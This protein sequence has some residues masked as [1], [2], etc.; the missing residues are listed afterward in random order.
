MCCLTIIG[1]L[2]S[3]LLSTPAVVAEQRSAEL[4]WSGLDWFGQA[5]VDN[6]LA[7]EV[8][9]PA[10]VGGEQMPAIF[11][12][13]RERGR[14]TAHFPTVRTDLAPGRRVFFLGH[15]GISDGFDW[16]DSQRAP[17]GVRF[18][19]AADGLDL[20]ATELRESIWR[21]VVA[22]LPAGAGPWQTSLTLATDCGAVG[23][24]NYDWAVFGDPI[25]VAV[26]ERPLPAEVLV[27]GTGGVLVAQVAGGAGAL[28]VEG[29]SAEGRPLEG[30]VATT[31]VPPDTPLAAVRFDFGSQPG[32]IGWRW[33]A[34]GLQVAQAWG[35]SWG[36]QAVIE[37]FGPAQAVT[38]NGEPLRVRVILGNRGL[39]A[40]VPEHGMVVECGGQ[41]QRVEH[42]GPGETAPFEFT[43]GL[44]QPESPAVRAA[45]MAGDQSQST[46]MAGGVLVWP[47]P[48]ELPADRPGTARAV[49]LSDDYV[50]V[51]NRHCR[52]L[53]C[54]SVPGLGALVYV[55]ADAGWELAGSVVPFV[56]WAEGDNGT[57]TPG[58]PVVVAQTTP[59]GVR[60]EATTTLRSWLCRILAELPD[61]TP[62]LKVTLTVEAQQ[63]GQL[64]ALWGPAVHAGDRA[65]GDRKGIAIFPGLE[66][67]EGDEPS[68]STRD[69]A[70][71]HHLRQVPH[72][73]KITVP[74]MMVET[75]DGGPVL[76]VAWDPLQKWEG[77]HS[78]PAACFSSPDRLTHQAS[79]L[80]QLML[81]S[82]PEF[83][84]EN[85]R[86]AVRPLAV[87]PG[88]PWQLV[89]YLVAGQPEPDA[90]A[91]LLWFD[92]LVGYPPAEEAPRSFEDEVA[93][94]RHG[95]MVTCWDPD[96]K[97]GR[98]VVGWGS[99]NSPGFATLMLMD[100]RAVARGEAQAQVAERVDLIGQQTLREQGPPGLASSANCHIMGWE[101]PFHWGSLPGA[102][103]GMRGAAY[104]SLGSQE[105]DGGWGYYPDE[106]RRALGEPGT[107][108]SGI[109]GQNAYL[110]AKYAAISGDPQVLA[111]MTRA[112]ERLRAFKVPRGAQGWECPILEPDVLASAYCLRACVWAY[113]ATGDRRYLDDARFWARTGLPFQYAWDD[114]QRPGMRYASIPVFGSTFFTHSWIGLPVQWCGLVYAYGLQELMRFEPDDLWRRQVEG[115]T[116]SAMHQQWPL[117]HPELAGTYPDSYGNWFTHRNPVFINPENIQLNLLALHGLDPGLRSVPLPTDVG[118]LHVTGP[119][120]LQARAE[121]GT[122]EVRAR[123]LPDQIM[124]LTLAPVAP[125]DQATVTGDTVLEPTHDLPTGS[126]GWAYNAELRILVVGVRCDGQGEARLRIS[127]FRR[128]EA[129][130]AVTADRWEFET[131]V[132]GW[133]PGNACNVMW[134]QGAL[135]IIATGFDP[136][137][138][139]SPT[140]INARVA[141]KLG[142][143]VRLTGGRAVG[144]FW[145]TRTSPH[146]GEDKHV[147]VPVPADG[148]WHELEVDLSDQRLWTGTVEQLR[149]DIEPAEVA[150]GTTL[151]VDWIRPL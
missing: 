85:A 41:R 126:T 139:S 1:H 63:P 18:Y 125:T 107:R 86:R 32:C 31:R 111:G 120:D 69:L 59:E 60:L 113:M 129:E 49:Q 3:L 101:F 128:Q 20:L 27:S 14:A 45:V 76:G 74:M 77:E 64:T 9:R 50:L 42:L 148:Q 95:F 94:C 51:E 109:C 38:F 56:E 131:D 62:A 83:V 149:L 6:A 116:V 134:D 82:T 97:K 57:D 137:V 73:F 47:Q 108:V 92:R 37:H 43:L 90:T 53:I 121:D 19:V 46:V 91:A 84:P 15:V 123:Y 147:D 66:Y 93:L 24:T 89:Q 4:L 33:R 65:T 23:N 52:W 151:D 143:R 115:M 141:K 39:G 104:G 119:C 55:W 80:M 138:H 28:T 135:R 35:G 81:P 114:G 11:L 142:L 127:G 144:L 103:A 44:P 5:Q 12:H 71:P 54:K 110:L 88:R 145:R 118:L 70:P 67:L 150:A 79:H 21:P 68:S 40:V 17:D 16:N 124:Y 102:L 25:L 8:R 58:F 122:V 61:N 29:L 87:A 112:M 75:R 136:Y 140:S 36:P 78:Q 117:D 132:H 72:R 105:D 96:T 7:A 100:A 130:P 2:V 133:T 13:P 26:D 34:E 98:H 48:P 146:W 99:A 22:E 30:A 10:R 106:S